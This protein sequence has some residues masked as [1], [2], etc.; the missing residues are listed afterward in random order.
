VA[1]LRF[2]PETLRGIRN[3]GA[4][5]ASPSARAGGMLTGAPQQSL[6]NIFARNVGTLLGRDMRTPQERL[7]QQLSQVKNPL[8]PEGLLKRA[9]IIAANSTDPKALQVAAALASESRNLKTA[10]NQKE[11]SEKA[12]EGDL[13]FL[14]E[15]EEYSQYVDDYE[16]FSIGPEFVNKLRQEQ[17]AEAA[18]KRAAGVNK[19][20]RTRVYTLLGKLYDVPTKDQTII[21]SGDL[22]YL[23]VEEFKKLYKPE[24]Q[25]AETV[26]FEVALD[27]QRFIQT[28]ETGGTV[29][30]AF[31]QR[32]DGKVLDS[33]DR[34]WKELSDVGIVRRTQ[35]V[36]KEKGEDPELDTKQVFMAQSQGA[37][38]SLAKSLSG[39]NTGQRLTV[40]AAARSPASRVALNLAG[41]ELGTRAGAVELAAN[42]IIE[43]V[44]R[45]LSGAAIKVDERKEFESLLT[46]VLTDFADPSLIFAKLA[47]NYVGFA[48]ANQ[49]GFTPNTKDEAT[50]QKNADILRQALEEVAK[51]PVTP[52]IQKLVDEGRFE[53]ALEMRK[54][55]LL[56]G[57]EDEITLESLKAKYKG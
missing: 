24:N 55:Q 26:N 18:A 7:Q 30:R 42:K 14:K 29:I 17:T 54:N 10:Q 40:L 8:S 13:Q 46:P 9:Q 1:S 47:N 4:D 33:K 25:K 50:G 5:L 16:N 53:E 19:T 15:N 37:T 11:I 41:T 43:T 52:E 27:P 36:E 48:V 34:K 3:F 12:R 23:E 56:G 38:V 51:E 32:E 45:D 22:S 6:P 35:A 44:A 21:E 28:G 49:L 39:L 20:Q 2:S 57:S 31:N